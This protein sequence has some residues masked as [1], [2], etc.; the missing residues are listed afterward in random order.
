M[1]SDEH[2]RNTVRIERIF[3][4]AA[5]TVFDAWT[6]VEVLRRW[7]PAGPGWETPVAEVDLRVGGRLRL[8]MRAPDGAEFGGEGR[9]VEINRPTR[10]VFTWQWDTVQLGTQL[11][12]VEVTFIENPDA[13]TTVV[14]V[15]QGLT[16]ADEQ[17][18]REGW[19][20]SFD[21]L[22][23]IL[24]SGQAAHDAARAAATAVVQ[25]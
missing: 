12:L 11:Q 24:G 13:T 18:H 17:S 19:Q 6:S 2:N 1:T 10:L 3:A 7:W 15:N 22:D 14:L 21:N 9:Y 5:T 4:A 25:P 16:E 8:V 23:G 20:A